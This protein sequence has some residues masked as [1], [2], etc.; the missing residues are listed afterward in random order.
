VKLQ[1]NKDKGFMKR[2]LFYILICISGYLNAQSNH[3]NGY[4]VYINYA[5]YS[6][7]A[8]V[9]SSPLNFNAIKDL[10]YYWYASNKIYHTQGGFDGKILHGQFVS[11]YLSNNL[12]EKGIFK[13]GL[14]NG[15]W[16]SWFENGKINE[17]TSWKRG[18]A[19]GTFRTFNDAGNLISE[20]KY[21][22]G[23]LHGS[24]KEYENGKLKTERKFK[25]GREIIKTPK[26][27]KSEKKKESSLKEKKAGK[28]DQEK[29]TLN[30]KIRSLF[31]KDKKNNKNNQPKEQYIEKEKK[32]FLSKFKKEN[33]KQKTEKEQAKK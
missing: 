16:I 4:T 19:N 3:A 6:I 26:P 13:K 33:K 2:K 10:E 12:K 32:P 20:A 9:S 15:S 30:Q 27:V 17:M 18:L 31:N 22:N 11:F 28:P 14:K 8:E 21:R 5:S 29:R 24:R 7:R 1:P 25:R 23:K